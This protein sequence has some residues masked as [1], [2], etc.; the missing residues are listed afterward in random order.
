MVYLRLMTRKEG[1]MQ[2]HTFNVKVAQEHG[3]VA[4]ILYRNFQFWIAK[5]KADGRHFYDGRTWT[6]NTRKGLCD[7]FSYLGE[8]QIRGAIRKLIE[9]GILV[10]GNYNKAGFDR[11]LWYAFQDERTAFSGCPAHWLK[12]PM[13]HARIT[14]GLVRIANQYQI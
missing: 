9:A 2:E 11:T 12:Q 13:Q 3:I 6:Y 10:K 1:R 14:N 5:N 7:L 4:A 8:G